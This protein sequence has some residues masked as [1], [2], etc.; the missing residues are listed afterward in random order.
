MEDEDTATV[1]CLFHVNLGKAHRKWVGLAV[2][3]DRDIRVV[4][5]E[6]NVVVGIQEKAGTG[7]ECLISR[8]W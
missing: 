1:A 2:I 4:A 6:N 8:A 7:Q 3:R 5:G